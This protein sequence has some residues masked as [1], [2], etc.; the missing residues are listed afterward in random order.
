MAALGERVQ[1]NRSPPR[2]RIEHALIDVAAEMPREIDA[3]ATLADA[4]QYRRTT[5]SRLLGTLEARPRV[6]S[7]QFLEDVLRDIAQGTCSALE[8]GYLDRVE[9]PHGIPVGKRQAPAWSRG[10]IYR[11][12]DYI[13]HG[14]HVELD[15]RL[16]HD[17]ASGRDR[18]LDRDLDA[19]VEG[20]LTVRLG[21][22]QVFGR[23]CA[24]ARRIGALLQRRGWGGS[25][26]PC[27]SFNYREDFPRRC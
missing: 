18:D 8:H 14:L 13:E 15:G 3:I 25:V 17:S 5:A 23:P 16:F 11:D 4:V 22:G 26:Q 19:F 20:R 2:V 27:R 6:S 9:R 24:T 1:W 12:V 21:W 7:R 10:R